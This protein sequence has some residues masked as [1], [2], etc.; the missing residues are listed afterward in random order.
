MIILWWG[1]NNL[2]FN[3]NPTVCVARY[4]RKWAMIVAFHALTSWKHSSGYELRCRNCETLPGGRI[5]SAS[6]WFSFSSVVE[7]GDGKLKVLKC[8]EVSIPFFL[9]SN[10]FL[11]KKS[12]QFTQSA[13]NFVSYFSSSSATTLWKRKSKNP[14]NDEKYSGA[15]EWWNEIGFF[16]IVVLHFIKFQTQRFVFSINTENTKIENW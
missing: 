16:A 11:I 12:Q 10:L 6:D 4:C 3:M 7:A 9:S 14:N 15:P 2:L 8:S 1:S 13:S 5:E